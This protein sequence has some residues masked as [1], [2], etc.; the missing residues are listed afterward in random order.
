MNYK[1]QQEWCAEELQLFHSPLRQYKRAN[2]KLD[3]ETDTPMVNTIS[4]ICALNDCHANVSAP[5]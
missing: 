5:H 1:H 3:S 2:L 4:E